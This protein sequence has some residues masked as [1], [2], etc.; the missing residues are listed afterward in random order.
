MTA[1]RLAVLMAAE[2]ALKASEMKK[3]ESITG[4]SEQSIPSSAIEEQNK[5]TRTQ[6]D[7]QDKEQIQSGP[8]AVGIQQDTAPSVSSHPQDKLMAPTQSKQVE[9][10]KESSLGNIN[11]QEKLEQQQQR[12]K[13]KPQQKKTQQ[14]QAKENTVSVQDKAVE[15]APTTSNLDIKNRVSSESSDRTHTEEEIAMKKAA[16]HKVQKIED[17]QKTINEKRLANS[18]D[19]REQRQK[20]EARV[21]VQNM[22]DKADKAF[23][24]AERLIKEAKLANQKAQDTSEAI[25]S[26]QIESQ[27]DQLVNNDITSLEQSRLINE[28]KISDQIARDAIEKYNDLRKAAGAA[29]DEFNTRFR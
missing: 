29:L 28:A 9:V 16:N 8:V 5:S 15:A 26:L 2:N 14:P 6:I 19:A 18:D 24:V 4:S 22:I 3:M 27:K 17:R 11:E 7:S 20:N 12:D 10:V 23:N 25:K 21:K 1:K 13:V